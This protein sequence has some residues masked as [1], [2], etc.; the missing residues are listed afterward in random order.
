M[1]VV[2]AEEMRYIDRK[3][4]EDLSVPGIVLMERAGLAV[5]DKI[6]EIFGK[7]KV[8]VVAGRGNNG[9]DGMVAARNLQNEGW[10]VEVFLTSSPDSLKDDA[11]A[12]YKAATEY[13]IDIHPVEELFSNP[14]HIE[15]HSVIVDAVLGTGLSKNVSES[16]SR[17]LNLINGSGVP[18]ISVDIPSGISSDNGQIMGSAIKADYTVTFGLPK[19]GHFLYPGL[20]YTGKLF[21][22]DIGFR[23]DLLLSEKIGVDLLSKMHVESLMPERPRYSHKGVYGHVLMVAGSRGKTGAA[24]MCTE[25]CLRTGA[26]LL[27]IGVPESLSDIF[28]SRVTE[29]MTLPLP[30]KGDSTLS[31]KAT[32]FIIDFANEMADV[33]AIGPGMGVSPETEK[34]I[35]TLIMHSTKPLILDADA[36]N[37]LRGEKEVLKKAKS[38]LIITPHPGEMARLM[39]NPSKQ[40]VRRKRRYK[41]SVKL[42]KETG[43][44]I[45]E[46]EEDRIDIALK[47]SR[48]HNVYLVLKGVPT[49]ISTPD[50]RA[51]I[52]STGNPGMA[53]AGTG[54]VLTGMIAGF[55]SQN[56]NPLRSC[57]LGVYLHGLA[58]D[59][60]ATEKGQH[61]LIA[62]DIIEKIPA[63]FLTLTHNG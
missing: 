1:K 41:T 33:V 16:L 23:R 35:R 52:N 58:G 47:F 37:S 6:K 57:I 63:A 51:F 14:Y 10:D 7:R 11:L 3:T 38:P 48:E 4:I 13:G 9:G 54:D 34:I 55:L 26:G 12:Q 17:V 29:A 5:S 49:V 44:L 25:S 46:I 59:I 40:T 31:V 20:E 8:I 60:A 22:E 21:I 28:Y 24:F 18:I 2:T 43:T 45:K 36:I 32:S 19:R 62:S 30:D 50:G 27:T 39:G 56:K 15:Q 53:T 61:S 42:H